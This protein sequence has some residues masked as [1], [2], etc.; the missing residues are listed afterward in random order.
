M[1]RL[2]CGKYR[3]D[4]N[5]GLYVPQQYIPEDTAGGRFRPIDIIYGGVITPT[6]EDLKLR[7]ADEGIKQL[8]HR[9]WYTINR[10]NRRERYI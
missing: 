2:F 10:I 1:E 6:V 9:G 5:G 8:T 4:E 7:K 3:V